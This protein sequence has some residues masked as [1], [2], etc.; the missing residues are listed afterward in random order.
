MLAENVSQASALT[1]AD[2]PGFAS[3]PDGQYFLKVRA[4]DQKGLE[5]YDAVHTFDLN[6]QPFAPTIVKPNEAETLREA[7]PQ[8]AW[9][10]IK[11]ANNYRL[12]I[13]QDAKFNNIIDSR[14]VNATVYQL[15]KSLAPG[16]YYWRLASLDGDDQGPYGKVNRFSY[17][18]LP[19]A[20]DVSQL[21]INV[22]QN[23]VFVTT[24]NPPDGLKY[25]AILQNE[26][27]HQLNVWSG[28][29][30]GAQFD[31]LLKEYGK[32]KLLLRHVE[33][34]GTIGA[35]AT[36]EFDAPAP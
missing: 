1:F 5:G 19:T 36:I 14:E 25:Q 16:Q 28:N 4:R 10:A 29:N 3:V 26:Q 27:N 11:Q 7:N 22:L 31:F 2:V 17:K 21:K 30:L 13:A 8:L 34:D 18:P 33:A 20:P 35:D 32:Q 23:R 9:T 24:I 12:E 6:A 15:E